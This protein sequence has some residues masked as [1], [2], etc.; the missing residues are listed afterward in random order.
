[1]KHPSCSVCEGEEHHWMPGWD[2][3]KEEAIYTC[4]HCEASIDP[5]DL[6]DIEDEDYYDDP[7]DWV[8]GE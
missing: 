7:D 8:F 6:D 2:D 5:D 3:E 4:K 1:M